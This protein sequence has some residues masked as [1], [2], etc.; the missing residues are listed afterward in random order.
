MSAQATAST[1]GADAMARRAPAPARRGWLRKPAVIG[2]LLVAPASLFL[3][4]VFVAPSLQ[5]VVY[6]FTAKTASGVM[7]EAF[8]FDNYARLIEVDLYRR[9]LVRTLR[10]ALITSA[11][12]V[13][14]AYPLA[15]VMVRGSPFWSR[16]V[17]LVVISPLLVL[18]V[19]RSYGWKL[20]LAKQGLLNWTLVTLG[21]AENPPQ[22][23]Y[24]E[25]AVIIASVHVFLPFIVLP[26]ASAIG[27]IPPSIEEAARTLGADARVIFQRIIIP[28]SL[29]GLVVGISLVFSLTAASY[30]TPQ[31]LG[32]NFTAM[33]GSLVEQQIFANNDWPF[34]A[35]IATVLIAVTLTA[36][37]LFLHVLERRFRRWTV[38]RSG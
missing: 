28:M 13:P 23:L 18:V 3:I 26:L 15:F 34:A 11:I 7:V 10:I 19:V 35:A 31:L 1:A 21:I 20:I 6:S 29:P 22:I 36:N 2:A 16:I 14:I 33:L 5:M 30:V 8:G 24:T 37:L 27:K 4:L 17:M 25:W 38:Q 32:G 9:V 12:A